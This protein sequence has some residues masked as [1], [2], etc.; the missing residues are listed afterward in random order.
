MKIM[1]PVIELFDRLAV[2]EIKWERTQENYRKNNRLD[3]VV[4]ELPV[5]P[6]ENSIL[7]LALS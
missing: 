4:L 5:L 2:A 3:F 6:F 1:F 7:M